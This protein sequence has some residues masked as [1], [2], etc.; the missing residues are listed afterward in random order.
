MKRAVLGVL[1]VAGLVIMAVGAVGHRGEVFAQRTAPDRGTATGGEL[2]ALP[3]PV[4]AQGQFLVVVDSRQRSMSVYHIDKTTG[5]IA[6]RSVR[7]IH[8]DMQMSYFDNEGLLPQ[9]IRSLLEQR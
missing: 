2:I 4:S 9:E 5:K 1:A 3:G 6:L 8:W 7:N